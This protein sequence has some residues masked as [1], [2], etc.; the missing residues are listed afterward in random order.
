MIFCVRRQASESTY[1]AWNL[2]IDESIFR[3]VQNYTVVEAKK[4]NSQWGVSSNLLEAF[5]ALQY[6]RG[7][8]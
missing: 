5:I 4:Q 8:Y 3:Q 2:F 6:A 7:I 1:M